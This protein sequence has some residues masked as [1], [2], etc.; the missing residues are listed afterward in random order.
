MNKFITGAILLALSAT[1]TAKSYPPLQAATVEGQAVS[2]TNKVTYLKF[3]ATWCAY[4]VEEMPL[5]QQTYENSQGRYQVITV[6]VGFNQTVEG[7][8]TY[9]NRYGYQFPT[10][11]DSTGAIT[12]QYQVTGT[13]Q[14]ILLDANGTE[15]YR[16]A[17]M[18]DELKQHLAPQQQGTQP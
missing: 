4:C 11:F 1:A 2:S 13:P 14:H 8:K 18:T 3:W 16:S 6:N 12:R 10:V 9:L 17:L 5:L 7:V 15:I